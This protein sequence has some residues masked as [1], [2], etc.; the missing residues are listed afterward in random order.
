MYAV[1]V[2]EMEDDEAT[3]EKVVIC[4]TESQAVFWSWRYGDQG[5]GVEI[6]GEVLQAFDQREVEEERRT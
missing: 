5:K 6:T 1:I 2:Y 3:V 4:K